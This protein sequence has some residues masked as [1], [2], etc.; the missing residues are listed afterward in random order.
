MTDF[1]IDFLNHGSHHLL[2]IRIT[3]VASSSSSSPALAGIFFVMIAEETEH[4]AYR[5][6]LFIG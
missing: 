5:D 6:F 4:P 2:H 3:I 1:F